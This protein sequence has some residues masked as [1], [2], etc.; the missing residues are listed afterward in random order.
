[1]PPSNLLSR[2]MLALGAASSA[3]LGAWHD[4]WTNPDLA[5]INYQQ[6]DRMK[7]YDLLW[8]YYANTA[9]EDTLE[10]AI[11]RQQFGLYR[12]MRSIYNPVRRLVDMYAGMIY[13]GV[14]SEDGKQLPDGV[15][16]AI[17]LAEDTPT[18]LRQ[19]ISQFWQWSNWQA[20][21]SVM[22][23]YASALGNTLVE[24]T[25]DPGAQK[26]YAEVV[27]PGT[28][29]DVQVDASG[30]VTAYV[31][32]YVTNDPVTQD[33]YVFSK[34]VTRTLFQTY[35]DGELTAE[36]P[37]PYGF[38]PAIWVPHKAM[39]GT[40]AAPAI[41][42]SLNKIDEMNSLASHTHDQIHKKV[43]SPMILWA[44]GDLSKVFRTKKRKADDPNSSGEGH[45]SNEREELLMLKGPEGG[46]VDSLAGTLE[47]AE[48]LPYIK[49]LLKEIEND[50]PE[51]TMY[52]E[53]RSMAQISGPAAARV[54]GD[55][56][57][58]IFEAQ[59]N[60]DLHSVKLFQMG[61]AIAG[62]RLNSGDWSLFG[63]TTAQQSRFSQFDLESYHAGKMDFAIM[64]RPLVVQTQHE[65]AS[66]R[67][68]EWQAAKSA[69]DA[70]MPLRIYLAHELKW[71]PAEITELETAMNSD[72]A[73]RVSQSQ[74]LLTPNTAPNP[75]APTNPGVA[76]RTGPA[77]PSQQR[78]RGN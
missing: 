66:T 60:Y 54:V 21:K 75:Q 48:A 22:V 23:R 37:N 51:L 19:A 69:T 8:S 55:A 11:R 57:A 6:I 38:A 5:H 26:V 49:E 56:A 43:A 16:L 46:R 61:V 58:Q 33:Q 45:Q 25:D 52:Q 64:A 27:W 3:A 20:N 76:V 9:W 14:L 67:Q 12:Q 17:P 72:A 50:H 42:G 44:S 36:W 7:Q 31:I 62:W 24:I 63:P 40:Y 15:P 13:P 59:S 78:G 71:T 41:E 30:N 1:M 4:A 73:K 77:R 10:W 74:A 70:G 34:V 29:A 65:R 53:L 39:G 32:Q 47:L 2:T 28:V 35:R 18:S 68:V